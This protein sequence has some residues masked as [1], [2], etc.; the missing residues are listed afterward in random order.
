M[1]EKYQGSLLGTAVGDA[2]GA[3]YEGLD[4]SRR[5][6]QAE[7]DDPQI[8]QW[9]RDI[10][11]CVAE[12]W[13]NHGGKVTELLPGLGF[14]AKGE[15]T[16]DTARALCIVESIN[17]LGYFDM[18][19]IVSRTL[20]WYNGGLGRGC[21]GTT[22]I[23][24]QHIENGIPWHEAGTKTMDEGTVMYRGSN[25]KQF[26][27]ITP[28][29]GNGTVM[30]IAPIGLFFTDDAEAID[31]AAADFSRATHA[32]PESILA[33]QVAANMI[34]RLAI[35]DSKEEALRAVRQ[36]FSPAIVDEYLSVPEQTFAHAGGAKTTLGIALT[37][38]MNFD[39]AEDIITASVNPYTWTAIQKWGEGYNGPDIDT[40]AAVA[41]AMAGLYYGVESIPTRWSDEIYP[42]SAP[43]ITQKATKLFEV[44]QNR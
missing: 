44:T 12:L 25:Q 16:D 26:W 17:A 23:A 34:G 22:G 11:T 1:I 32:Y 29:P 35:G 4:I 40:Y 37:A 42:V 19:D 31:K 3:P 14:W 20:N 27:E 28:A 21:G 13:D 15:T 41:G 10:N 36:Y 7:L 43:E 39:N 38:F 18:D 9:Q 24:L 5:P 6:T 8:N 33:C 2:L 30:C